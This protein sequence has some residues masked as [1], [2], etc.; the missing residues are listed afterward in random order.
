MRILRPEADYIG[1]LFVALLHRN[2]VDALESQ[3]ERA[4][5]VSTCMLFVPFGS[6]T[7]GVDRRKYRNE[8]ARAN[9]ACL[10]H[11]SRPGMLRGPRNQNPIRTERK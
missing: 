10:W 9:V 5:T 6:Q 1:R 4:K 7:Q 3:R 2:E 8:I 11:C